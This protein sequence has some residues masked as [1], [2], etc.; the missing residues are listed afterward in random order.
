M[1]KLIIALITLIVSATC[2]ADEF[3]FH[4]VKII[5][6]FPV[7]AGPDAFTRNLV[8]VLSEKWKRPVILD[9]RPGGNGIVAAEAF[10]ADSNTKSSELH[11]Y[12]A[13]SEVLN[14]YA[15]LNQSEKYNQVLRPLIPA[16]KTDMVIITSSDTPDWA[17]FVKKV[18]ANPTYGSWSVASCGHVAGLQFLESLNKPG[19]HLPYRDFNQWF[20]DVASGQLSFSFITIASSKKLEQAGKLKYMAI[21]SDRRNPDYPNVPTL[22]ELAGIKV[23][24]TQWAAYYVSRNMP[25]NLAQRLN[26]DFKEA[27]KSP[28]MTDTYSALSYQPW[29]LTLQEVADTSEKDRKFLTNATKKYNIK[30]E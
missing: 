18:Q 14:A 3:P 30:I 7:G 8:E 13:A 20:I 10:I 12:L 11:I 22:S 27:M 28:K 25:E 19:I 15:V 9:A 29:L 16:L 21:T 23:G 17:S 26:A 24:L 1:K 2:W 6:A 4:R 5:S